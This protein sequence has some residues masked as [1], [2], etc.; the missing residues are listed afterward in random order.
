M[1]PAT[2]FTLDNGL[3][4]VHRHDPLTAMANINVVYDVGARDEDRHLT[5]MA[6]LF[7]HLM[8]SGSVNIPRFDEAIERAGGIN[9][10]WTSQDYT[11]FYSSAPAVNAETLFWLESDRMLALG[12]SQEALDVQRNVVIEEFK[13]VCLNRPYGT[14]SHRLNK[15]LYGKH[16]YAVPVI[17]RAIEE[18]ERVTLDDIKAFFFSHYAP[19]NAVLSIDGNITL[20]QAH[21]LTEKYF[22]PIERRQT[23]PRRH[24]APTPLTHPLRE[25]MRGIGAQTMVMVAYPMGGID[26]MEYIP[27]DLGSDIMASGESSRMFRDLVMRGDIYAKADASIA[28]TVEAGYF[29]LRALLLDG[30]DDAV[31]R[32]EK[33]LVNEARKIAENGV[34]DHELQRALNRY[35]SNDTFSQ[36]SSL[37]RCR[38]TA[39]AEIRGRHAEDMVA[40]YRHTTT[41]DIQ[42]ATQKVFDTP[43]TATLIH[44]PLQ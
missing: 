37:E 27:L 8:F 19:N 16:P 30:N 23:T 35:E 40:L 38:M 14:V 6:H 10:A 12:F 18:L 11:S 2:R 3:R 41:K 9:N 44:R 32:A 29:L 28:G 1:T 42:L 21:T 22:A 15:M 13:Q 43:N 25:E 31:A 20:E 4:V 34:T 7:E 39:D 24:P 26:S 5:G 17:G 33:E 36:I